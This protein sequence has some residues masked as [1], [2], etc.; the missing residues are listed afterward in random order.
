MT[1]F[2]SRMKPTTVGQYISAAPRHAQK[3]LREIRAILKKVAP[4]ATEKLKWGSPAF[5]ARGSAGPTR[6]HRSS[7]RDPAARGWGI[8]AIMRTLLA[9]SALVMGVGGLSAQTSSRLNPVIPLWA[10][11]ALAKAGFWAR[12][13]FS[14]R[15]SPE[16]ESADLD[17]DGL[18]DLIIA[19]VDRGARRRGLAIVHQIDRSVH[20]VG[21]GSDV[22]AGRDQLP[23]DASWGSGRL[24]GHREAIRVTAWHANAWIVWNGRD[25]VWVPDSE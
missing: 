20:I 1:I 2:I 17:G 23:S 6:R 13:D 9:V 15:T 25:Y 3:K 4:K 8:E 19:I 18:G 22:T 10:D 5:D 21:A 24:P 7:A 14:S 11:S 12:Y 16:I